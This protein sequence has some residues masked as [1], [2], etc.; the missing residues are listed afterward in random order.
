V[1]SADRS[2]GSRGSARLLSSSNLDGLEAGAAEPLCLGRSQP[3]VQAPEEKLIPQKLWQRDRGHF[4]RDLNL[5]ASSEKYLQRLE[6]GLSAGLAALAEAVQAGA[7][8]IEGDELRLS[9]RKPGPKGPR[10][11]PARQALARARGDVQFPEVLIEI[12]GLTQFSWTLL[13]R[14][15]RSE[16]ELV[17]LY[18]ALM[19]LGSDLSAAELERMVPTLAADSIG[20]M[21]LHRIQAMIDAAPGD[22]P[23]E[24]MRRLAPIGHKHINMRGIL[25][26]DLAR[27][28]SSLLRQAP[29][30]ALERAPG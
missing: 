26:F 8:A 25:T 1:A 28:R 10:V 14:P 22:H 16:P 9:R 4:I 6:A 11:E 3:V 5:P 21:M 15:A 7:A 19:G 27:Y 12:D 20:Q 17:T 29:S 18:A 13:G 24:M 30:A 2:A 23:D